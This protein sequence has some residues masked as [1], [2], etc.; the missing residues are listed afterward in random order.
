[1]KLPHRRKFLH[2]AAGAAA[3]PAVSR[4]AR[5]QAYPTPTQ[6]STSSSARKLEMSLR[7]SARYSAVLRTR[8]AA[9][10]RL[11]CAGCTHATEACV[12]RASHEEFFAAPA[13]C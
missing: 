12:P 11:A 7:N 4:V 2:L 3:L 1:M 10:A 9:N 13:K 8:S 6:P 5:A